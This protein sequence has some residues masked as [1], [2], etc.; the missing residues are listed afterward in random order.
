[1]KSKVI[2]MMSLFLLLSAC[3]SKDSKNELNLSKY[4]AAYE[5]LISN[6]K[7][8][9]T[10]K[11]YQ[12]EAVATKL[13]NGDVRVDVILDQAN[14]A[15]YN[16]AMIM[17]IHNSKEIQDDEIIPSL[18]IVDDLKYNIIPNQVNSNNNFYAGLVL[19]AISSNENGQVKIGVTWT[20]YSGT[21]TFD[22]VILMP[23]STEFK[24]DV[25]SEENVDDE[26]VENS[27]SDE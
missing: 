15:M 27:G 16:I 25:D 12:L 18:G 13:S 6:D 3:S 9:N 23:Y 17:D 24:E 22:E 26:D 5:T 8:L 2:I 10:S 19:S 4:E 11:F 14:V 7:P 20:N 21:E 1:M